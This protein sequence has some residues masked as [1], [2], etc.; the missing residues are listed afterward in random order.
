MTGVMLLFVF[1]GFADHI[2][3]FYVSSSETSPLSL[4]HY[5]FVCFLALLI[6]PRAWPETQSFSEVTY[7]VVPYD[8]GDVRSTWCTHGDVDVACLCTWRE[9]PSDLLGRIRAKRAYS[10]LPRESGCRCVA[11]FS[12]VAFQ[13]VSWLQSFV[14]L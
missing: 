1:S 12:G 2:H 5:A 11:T 3:S 13:D 6:H 10:C 9:P 7:F 14:W 4:L 8:S